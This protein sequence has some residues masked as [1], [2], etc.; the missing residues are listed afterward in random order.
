MVLF[1]IN[2]IERVIVSQLHRSPGVFFDH[3]KG[4]TH[5]S[6]KYLF[7][8]RVIPYRGSWLDF[9][10]DPKDILNVR[11]DRRR[12]LP[13]TTLLLALEKPDGEPD[14]D[15]EL[16]MIP[17]F[18]REE[19]LNH[20]YKVTT[21]NR[22]AKGW[23]VAYEPHSWKGVK[24]SYDL[25]DADTG[26]VVA[27]ADKKITA[28]LAKAM[29][30]DGVKSIL[31][32]ES[33]LIGKYVAQDVVNENT[34]EI[35]TES[36][37]E[38]TADVLSRL[39][40]AGIIELRTLAIDYNNV[41]PYLRNTMA[42]DRNS[43]RADALIDIYRVMRPGEPPTL[44]SA[45]QLFKEL[46]FD[47]DKY[48]LSA[49]GRVKMNARLGFDPD[50]EL[51]VMRTE[52]FLKIVDILLNLKDGNGDI[53]DIDNL[54]NRRVRSVGE[55]MENQ[56]RVGLLRMERAIRERMGAVDVDSIMPHDLINAKPVAA[57]LREFFG[58]SQLS[59]FMDQTNPLSEIYA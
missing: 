29:Q 1:V 39:E 8:G 48:D 20:F 5:S 24:L 7:S 15:D 35:L 12:K 31:I 46:F 14:G 25:V 4:K 21:F 10:F 33:Q 44:E 9:E 22:V 49:V 59:Q 47:E 18:S 30:T 36:G 50:D 54:A 11:I 17:G 55:L 6:G 38:V 37:D 27:P 43:S 42:V 53:D 34:G 28:R 56:C 45:L 19:I 16:K 40:S 57:A 52:D 41:G 3:D 13:V 26:K 23:S 32:P 51:R 58:S 2:G